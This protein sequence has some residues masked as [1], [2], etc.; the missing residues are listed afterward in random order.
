MQRPYFV[1][2]S[3]G[4][5]S[6][7]TLFL[8]QLTQQMGL[9]KLTVVSQDNYY[10]PRDQQPLDAQGVQNFDTPASIDFE[11]FA[12]DL[13]LLR[14]G[15]AV[16]K[17]EYTF[18]NPNKTPR[19][20][21]FEPAPIIA[22][23]GLFVFYNQTVFNLFDL[24]IFVQSQEHIKLKR[25]IFRDNQERGY[26]LDDVLYR[27]ENHVYPAYEKYIAPFRHQCDVIIP[28]N[29]THFDNALAMVTTYLKAK[30]NDQ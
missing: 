22:V 17:L 15:Q 13:N 26:D 2:I 10:F 25:R 30:I 1:G 19:M 4:S 7:K 16:E 6:G 27:Y 9:D 8:N 5:A 29:N 28:N 24:K 11:S 18:N 23:E 12:H 14:Q 21:C 20:L 3:G